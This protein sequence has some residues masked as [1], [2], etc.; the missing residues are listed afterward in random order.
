MS[1]AALPLPFFRSFHSTDRKKVA[2]LY[3]VYI[4][5]ACSILTLATARNRECHQLGT[6]AVLYIITSHCLFLSYRL[7]KRAVPAQ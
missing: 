1:A 3:V 2:L 4:G 6:A 7:I 5:I